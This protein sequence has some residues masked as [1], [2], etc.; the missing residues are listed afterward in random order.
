M[1]Q[2][3]LYILSGCF[4]TTCVVA[5]SGCQ[6]DKD[7]QGKFSEE[8][9]AGFD[10]AQRRNLPVP[11][12]GLVLSINKEAITVDEIISPMMEALGP[13][14]VGK[15]FRGFALRARSLVAQ[16]VMSKTAD[17]LLYQQARK[18]AA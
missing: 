12:G 3:F 6:N 4:L 16:A 14:A 2:L 18:Q 9:M 1:R 11:S 15:D 8:Q 13:M 10:L 5:T 7:K 17:A